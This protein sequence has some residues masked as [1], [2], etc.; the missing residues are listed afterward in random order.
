MY[1]STSVTAQLIRGVLAAA[2][3]A[4]A[5]FLTPHFRPALALLPLAIFFMRGCPACWL[6]RLMEAI[7]VR[8]ERK[9]LL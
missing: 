1:C 6:V 5:I 7:R 3:I 2:S 4:G 8:S 9:P